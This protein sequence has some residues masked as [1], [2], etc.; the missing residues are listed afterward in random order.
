MSDAALEARFAELAVL[1]DMNMATVAER[2]DITR[3]EAKR[4]LKKASVQSLVRRR[5]LEG[6][7]TAQSIE[8]S[9][10]AVIDADLADFMC[11][12]R[13]EK[14][15]EELKSEGINT[16]VVKQIKA[17]GEVI[18][19]D[20]DKALDRA[21]QLLGFVDKTGGSKNAGDVNVNVGI[22]QQAAGDNAKAMDNIMMQEDIIV[23]DARASK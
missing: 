3:E 5:L 20:R 17:N 21:M 9:L 6:G 11:V 16:K 13:N 8:A 18:L 15:L 7:T 22:L 10:R 14:T 1:N 4:M 12:Q 23:Q 19:H 2:L